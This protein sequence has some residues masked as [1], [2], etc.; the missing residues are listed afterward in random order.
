MNNLVNKIFSNLEAKIATVTIRLLT[1]E[2]GP[3]TEEDI[4]TI[5]LRLSNLEY[6][7]NGALKVDNKSQVPSQ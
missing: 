4:P 3:E 2:L 5:L 1:K 6:K 7:K